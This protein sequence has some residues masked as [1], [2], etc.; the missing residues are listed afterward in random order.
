MQ[1]NTDIP[2][3][4]SFY[5]LPTCAIHH[6]IAAAA[7][8]III[9]SNVIASHHIR[10]LKC[11]NVLL[12]FNNIIYT[13]FLFSQMK[14]SKYLVSYRGIRRDEFHVDRTSCDNKIQWNITGNRIMLCTWTNAATS[15]V[16]S[17]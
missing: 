11:V 5:T 14:R 7:T 16:A 9:H 2:T 1:A 17:T 12:E 13:Y 6:P 8:I 3:C 4:L 15:T 10:G